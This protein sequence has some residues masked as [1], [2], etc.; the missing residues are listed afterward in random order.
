M[1]LNPDKCAFRIEG[2]KFLGFM[3]T[4]RGIE[5]NLE[6]C[7]A[8]TNM[9]SLENVKEIRRLVERLTT[10]LGSYQGY[11]HNQ[12][13][14]TISR[15]KAK[16][17]WTSECEGIFLQLK[18]FLVSPSYSKVESHKAHNNLPRCLKRRG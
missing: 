6:K 1:Q 5:A 16:F 18:A 4:H 3:L 2:E 10:F 9:V 13:H 8:I 17:Q 7:R 14:R 12:A 11:Q 15:N